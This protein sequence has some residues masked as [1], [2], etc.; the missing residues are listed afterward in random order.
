MSMQQLRAVLDAAVDAVIVIDA[1][2]RI[3]LANS[4][5]ECLFGWEA[6][7]L[8]G[9]DV[10]ML[11]PEPERSAHASCLE[12]HLGTDDPPVASAG[13]NVTAL[14]RDGSCFPA[15][16]SVGRVAGVEPPQFVGF[17]HDLTEQVREAEAARHRH[18]RLLQ[19]T[20]LATMG[21]MA[22]GIAH[23][24]NQ[25]LT[26]IT[27]YAQA[28]NRLLG[29]PEPDLV[30]SR[31]A[32]REIVAEAQR[33]ADIIRKL[34]RMVRSA[35]DTREQ[36]RLPELIEELRTLCLAEAR[37]HDTHLRFELQ[38]GVP[39]VSV[40]RLQITQLLFNLVRNALESVANDPPGARE[41]VICGRRSEAGDCQIAVCDNGPGVA[42][43][44]RDRM[45]EP[46]LTTKPS[47][48]GLGL[49][50]SQTIAHAHGGSLRHEPVSPRGAR[51][52]LT[53][54]AAGAA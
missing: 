24:V 5:T 26:A 42:P 48:T 10:G 13:R 50:M 49:P 45:F 19:V 16:L 21:E 39:P 15:R 44:V 46:F 18:E 53:L 38:A 41:V 31:E 27:N 3:L 47:G 12:R 20:R 54:P 40:H 30:D 8:P 36:T 28:A 51:F 37:A 22:A 32:L 17:V 7:S 34:R 4:A 52:I 35:E 1:G 25:P 43:Q 33:A 23:E 29:L 6:E 9:C 14:R 2:G 11:M